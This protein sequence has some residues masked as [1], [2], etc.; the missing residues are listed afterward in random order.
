MARQSKHTSH[1]G[2]ESFGRRLARLRK[3]AGLSQLE[4]AQH[5]GVAQ[6]LVSEYEHDR[7]RVH[8]QRLSGIARRLHVSVDELLG[9]KP[10]K[11]NGTL[12]LKLVRRLKG[13]EEL[14]PTKQKALLQLV[15][16]FLRD[17]KRE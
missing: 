12:S 11:T 4:L 14:P 3:A 15:D 5:L 10:S 13:I 9:H 17:S 6:T 7:R 1:T 8:G 2:E 16:A